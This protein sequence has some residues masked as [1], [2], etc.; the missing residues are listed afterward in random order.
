MQTQEQLSQEAGLEFTKWD[1]I[2]KMKVPPKFKNFIWRCVRN[3]LPVCEVLQTKGIWIGGGCSLCVGETETI[4]HLLCECPVARQLWEGRDL[5]RNSSF[6]QFVESV[7]LLS[8]GKE[9]LLMAARFWTVWLARNDKVFNNKIWSMTMLKEKMNYFVHEWQNMDT[10]IPTVPNVSSVLVCAW[11]PLPLGM[12]K[13]NVDASILHGHV[14]AGAVLRDHAGR[15]VAAFAT[16]LQCAPDP[17]LAE[18]MAIKEALSWFK[19][20]GV[21]HVILETDCLNFCS[22]FNSSC[23]DLSYVGILIKQCH[24]IARDIGDV[25][26]CHVKRSVNQV[27]HVLARATRSAS[28]LG[29]WDYVP[30]DCISNLILL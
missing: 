5:L 23:R 26:V 28:V 18:T 17:Y 27:A 14:G 20:R 3:I 29:V 2:W 25:V 10:A 12:L 9:A 8:D 13:C 21:N 6:S 1:H 30:P 16:R 11:S 22:S 19:T 4:A 15:F 7:L 24:T